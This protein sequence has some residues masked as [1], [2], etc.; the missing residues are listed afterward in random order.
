MLELLKTVA[1]WL[2]TALTGGPIG[3]AGMAAKTIADKIGLSDATVDGVKAALTGN[4]MTPEQMLSLKQADNDFS[5]QMQKLGF[6]HAENMAGIQVQQDTIAAGDRSS[7][8]QFASVVADHTARNLA[9]LYT[10]ALFA[11]IAAHLWII[12]QRIPI[13]P[14]AMNIISTL[15]GVLIA[16]VLGSK[17]FF[18]GS[19]SSAV[20][21][22]AAITDFATAPGTVLVPPD[23]TATIRTP[24]DPLT[25]GALRH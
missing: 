24:A 9:Y 12:V 16:M 23:S 2:I 14:V 11:V 10:G 7:A 19:S 15:E 3:L 20:K 17:E 13:E 6:T 8:R 18:F 21:Q 22:Q 25:G 1:P 4:S 5:M